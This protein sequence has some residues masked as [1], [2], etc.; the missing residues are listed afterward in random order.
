MDYDSGPYFITLPAGVMSIPFNVSITDDNVFEGN[1]S[2]MLAIN[3]SSLPSDVTV[4]NP[5]QT[6]VTIVDN[7]GKQIQYS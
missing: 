4:G 7:D 3:L 1:E 6:T 2:F 5:G